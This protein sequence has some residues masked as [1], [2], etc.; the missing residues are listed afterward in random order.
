MG[1]PRGPDLARQVWPLDQRALAQLPRLMPH[2]HEVTSPLDQRYNCIAHAAGEDN[3]WWWPPLPGQLRRL[4]E[5]WPP[6]VPTSLAISSFEIAFERKGYRR[7]DTGVVEKGWE[8]VAVYANAEGEPTHAARQVAGGMWTS[9][10]GA[11]QDIAH[12]TLAAVA[13]GAY[14]EPAI[15]MRRELRPEV[16]SRRT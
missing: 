3:R 2:N 9:K 4:H 1:G 15:F 6:G 12:T 10:L 11:Q 13:G 14:G 5:Y 7:C 16:E 8:K